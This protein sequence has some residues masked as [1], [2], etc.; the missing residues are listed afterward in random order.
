MV[1]TVKF[2]DPNG[3]LTFQD[4]LLNQIEGFEP[5][6]ASNALSLPFAAE[7][8]WVTGKWD[9][10]RKCLSSSAGSSQGDFNVGVGQALLA[11][12]DGKLN[13]FSSLLDNLRHNTV[14]GLSATNTASLQGCHDSM[15]RFHVLTEIEMISSMQK[16]DQARKS[17]LRTSLNLRLDTLGPF[18]SEKQYILGLRRAVMELSK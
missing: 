12:S 11:L 13:Q 14:R 5:S 10:L 17:S 18:L 6:E 15:L 4:V 1:G 8:S 9:N 2:F 3:I 7:A 16:V